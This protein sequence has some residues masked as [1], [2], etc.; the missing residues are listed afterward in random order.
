[1]DQAEALK[2]LQDIQGQVKSMPT[3]A[4]Q[5]AFLKRIENDIS[6]LCRFKVAG[7][8]PE[9]LVREREKEL[10]AQKT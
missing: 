2:E 10:E 5:A 6:F 3:H 4:G 8:T 9:L 1:M 7:N